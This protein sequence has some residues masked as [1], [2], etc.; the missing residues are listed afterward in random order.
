VTGAA[1]FGAAAALAAA[2]AGASVAQPPDA[3]RA[4]EAENSA[5]AAEITAAGTAL[6]RTRAELARLRRSKE[7]LE[8]SLRRI[9]RRAE[10]RA[11]G[12]E[13]ARVMT[14]DLRR[15][16]RPEGFAAARDE[17]RRLLEATGDANLRAERALARLGDLDAAVAGRV[18]AAPAAERPKLESSVHAALADQFGLLTRLDERQGELM[19]ALRDAGDAERDLLARGRAV[20]EQLTAL[21][22]W[23]PARTGVQAV[24]DLPA[25]LA[26]TTSPANWRAAAAILSDAAARSPFWPAVAVLLAA[27]IYAARGRLQRR[28]VALAPAAGGYE[29]YRLGHAL[30]ALAITLALALPGAILMCTAARLLG[31]APDAEPFPAALGVA[32]GAIAR[33]LLA[34]SALAWLLDPRGVAVRHFGWDE[35]AV[36]FAARALRRFTAFFVPLMLVAALNGLDHAPFANRESLGRA[37]LVL[38]MFVAVGFVVILMR[39]R[40]PLMAPLFLRTPR[41]WPAQLHAVWFGALLALPL[42]IGVLAA[43]G[44]FVAAGYFFARML[45][46]LFVVLGALMLYGLIALW[47]QIHCLRLV[48]RREEE[49]ARAAAGAGN[50]GEAGSELPAARVPRPDVAAIGEQTRSLLDL[51]ITLLVLAGLWWVWKDAVPAL[52]VIGDYQLWAYSDTGGGKEVTHP[53]TVRGLGLAILVAIVTA[54]AVRNVGALLDIVLL[55]R[56]ELQ[57][58]ATYAIKVVARY[59][60]TAAGVV[61]AADILGIGWSDVQWLIAALGVGLGFGLQEIFANFVSGLIVLAER[62]IRIGDVVTVGDVSGTVARIRARATAVVDFDNKE[63]IIPNKAFITERVVNWTLS[64]QTT[65]LLLKVGVAYGSDIGLV[66]RVMLEAVRRNPDVLESP[67]PSVFFADFGD[68]S[69]DFEIR[70]FVGSFNQRLRVQHELLFAVEAVLRENSVEIPFPQRDLHIRSAP[71]LSGVLQAERPG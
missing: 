54:V 16:P 14:E 59:A 13:F 6:D 69:L 7:E 33:L 67:P 15:L 34:L 17:R 5:L 60:L 1:R 18:A 63:V 47:V 4:I 49:A 45:E 44:Y 57:A 39:R 41:S 23:L 61:L 70:A 38:A 53:L 51:L 46:S 24:T 62:P 58:D 21:L 56:L 52:S 55:Q 66:Q 11:L 36:T 40:S 64:N 12:P 37:A 30:A 20:R 42:G 29:R 26:W 35:A 9:E 25:A 28:L 50:A 68:S 65:R 27:G 71:G 8:E 10:V 43:A 2:L 31:S 48:H 22:L 3:A 32:L 19:R